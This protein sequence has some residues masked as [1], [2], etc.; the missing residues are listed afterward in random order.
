MK[1]KI[2]VI[3]A[4]A[5]PISI[6][7]FAVAAVLPEQPKTNTVVDGGTNLI[8]TS[9]LYGRI[10]NLVNE[11]VKSGD[12]CQVR[13]HTW[14]NSTDGYILQQRILLMFLPSTPFEQ[15]TCAVCGTNQFRMMP[16]WPTP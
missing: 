10:T 7:A 9:R 3:A 5:A 1:T 13:G 12:F 15:R 16:E 4:L 2:N 11:L 6:A 14:T 8:F